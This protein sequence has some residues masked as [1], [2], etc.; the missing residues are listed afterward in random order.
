MEFTDYGTWL[1]E[2]RSS[3]SDADLLNDLA[4]APLYPDFYEPQQDSQSLG[5]IHTGQLPSLRME[6]D[7]YHNPRDDRRTAVGI[8]TQHAPI[9]P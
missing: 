9:H 2:A 7:M 5:P 4:S 3:P 6:W 1:L 8:C